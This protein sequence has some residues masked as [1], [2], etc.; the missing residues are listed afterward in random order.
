MATRVRRDFIPPEVLL[1]AYA[2]GYFPM[3]DSATGRIEWYT[4]DPRAMLPLHP[5]HV[6]RRLR[7]ALKKVSF[8]FT[9]DR[10][11]PDVVQACADRDSTW[12]NG[13]I[14][15]SYTALH[16]RGHA[17]SVEVWQEGELVGGLYGVHLGGAFFGESMFHRV[18]DASKAALVYLAEHLNARGF[19]LL[20]IQMV[21]P[22][23]AQFGA[24]LVYEREYRQLLA[25]A[26]TA[27]CSW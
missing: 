23:T 17:H 12:I 9:T 11:F 24:E 15:R 14:L 26:L 18:D 13:G 1:Q 27:H 3:A 5:F 6:P 8:T 25:E 22:L 7:R 10:A 16:E 19:Q 4:A 20:E 2:G 21:T